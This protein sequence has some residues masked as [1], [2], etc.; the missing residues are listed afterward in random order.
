MEIN[1]SGF[2][3]RNEQY[4]ARRILARIAELGIRVTVGSDSHTPADV[5]RYF[6][7]AEQLIAEYGLTLFEKN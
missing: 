3:H 4:P 7:K 5:G 2:F 6:D 1:T